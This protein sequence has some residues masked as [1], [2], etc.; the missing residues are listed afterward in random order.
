MKGWVYIITNKSAY[1]DLVKVGYSRQDP[2]YRV[3]SLSVGH[4]YDCVSEYEF[5]VN[6][7]SQIEKQA[8]KL[9]AS[10]QEGGEWF[11]CSIEDAVVAIR[12]VADKGII[13]EINN[14]E[15]RL[16]DNAKIQLDNANKAYEQKDYSAAFQIYRFLIEEIH[17]SLQ[18]KLQIQF[19]LGRMY[20]YG[21][22]IEQDYQEASNWYQKA[23]KQGHPIAKNSLE[24]CLN[25]IQ[26]INTHNSPLDELISWANKHKILKEDFPRD[27]KSLLEKRSL[28][29]R[30]RKYRVLHIP[31]G[32]GEL[33]NLFDLDFSNNK[34]THI[35]ESIGNLTNLHFLYL[36]RNNL[37]YI[38]N[39]IG[40]LTD[41]WKL[42]LS[43]NQFIDIPE[44][45][46]NLKN[47][48]ALYLSDNQIVELPKSIRKLTNLEK[49][50]LRKNPI[51]SLPPEL[52]HL[53]NITLFD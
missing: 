28:Y 32:I 21:Q 43:Y 38:P 14:H 23:A 34:I 49:L 42:D 31:D 13:T 12:K 17:V 41:L 37:M 47:L 3:K 8:H 18:D 36:S 48:K 4:P 44:S 1:P 6:N 20:E 2:E 40:K 19:R 27:K 50:D 33:K 7:P 53:H 26:L 25:F 5:L 10:K 11:R 16:K 46:G 51:K 52:N 9:L 15:K 29:S 35:P 39:S 30:S 24:K 45:I 22:G